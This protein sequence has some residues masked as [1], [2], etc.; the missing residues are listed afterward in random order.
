MAARRSPTR[1]TT[2]QQSQLDLL[3]GGGAHR[4]GDALDLGAAE[5]RAEVVR[6]LACHPGGEVR[7]EKRGNTV[8]EVLGLDPSQQRERALVELE[9]HPA[10]LSVQF[11][12]SGL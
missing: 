12:G 6:R 11:R 10:L 9:H 2:T 1:G 7:L 4:Q 8:S 5:E 3:P